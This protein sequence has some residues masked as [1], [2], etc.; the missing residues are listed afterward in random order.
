MPCCAHLQLSNAH[1]VVDL[2]VIP[3]L[4]LGHGDVGQLGF[5]VQH[6]L[7]LEAGGV[8]GPPQQ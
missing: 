8:R 3:P 7:H 4:S 5:E 1:L 6:L 2:L